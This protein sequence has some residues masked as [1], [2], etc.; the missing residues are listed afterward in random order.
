MGGRTRERERRWGRGRGEGSEWRVWR[1]WRVWFE[2]LIR[3]KPMMRG[4]AVDLG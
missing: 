3:A 2:V 4:D 1:L